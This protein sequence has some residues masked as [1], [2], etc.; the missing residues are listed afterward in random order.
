MPNGHGWTGVNESAHTSAASASACTAYGTRSDPLSPWRWIAEAGDSCC[1]AI[2]AG[3]KLLVAR[4][5]AWAKSTRR[6][7]RPSRETPSV[8]ST[9][10]DAAA[11]LRPGSA[12]PSEAC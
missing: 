10:F 7:G 12:P 1:L 5:P 8:H 3:M 6:A 4:G 11:P 9:P 2:V